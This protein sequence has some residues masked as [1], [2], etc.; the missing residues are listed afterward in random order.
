MLIK[1]HVKT[2]EKNESVHKV[3]NELYEISIKEPA[4]DGRANQRIL[5]ILRKEFPKMRIHII[6]GH[7][8]PH[9]IVSVE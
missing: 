2:E 6:S 3:G 8:A 9:K 4:L 7:H 5:E 1:I